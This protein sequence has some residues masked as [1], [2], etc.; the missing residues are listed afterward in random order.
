M[1]GPARQ[2]P[3]ELILLRQLAA[4]LTVPVALFDSD[5][6][7]IYLNPA[8]EKAFGVDFA[9]IGEL[10]LEGAYA[11]ARP[12]DSHGAPLAANT[13]GVAGALR[14]GRPEVRTVSIRDPHGRSHRLETTT[15]PVQGQGG[16]RL[17]AMSLFWR[18]DHVGAGGDPGPTRPA[19]R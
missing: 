6:R 3:I 4:R 17:G 7:L 13:G 1:A 19:G 15:I 8:A 5:A 14:E 16:A 11:I 18:L 9:A 2:Y 12:T 10:S